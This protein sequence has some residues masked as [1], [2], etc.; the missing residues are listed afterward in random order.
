METD[1]PLGEPL[2]WSG[3]PA[4]EPVPLSGAYVELWPLDPARDIGPLY[5]A[6]HLRDGDPGV[7]HYLYEGPFDS[8]ADYKELLESED[9]D[10][11]ALPFT[12]V[13][14]S[15]GVPEGKAS[16]LRIDPPNGS[17]EV[18]NIWLGPG[19]KRTTAATEAIFLL[20]RHAF[21]DLGYRRFEW[22][23]NALNA[24]S[25][26]AAARFGFTYEGTFR[27]NVV[28]KG[29]NRDT[30]WFSIIDSEWP[31]IRAAFEAWLAPSN[32][33]ADGRQKEPLRA[34]RSGASE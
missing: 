9:A 21:D 25:R 19:L 31:E 22:K 26:A 23:C 6:S 11:G 24:P 2:D 13:P 5:A 1:R 8:E 14:T 4:P 34:A 29:R 7:W 15:T 28:V 16:Y 32:F 27:Q 12:I 10:P 17:I 20:I 30:A 3:A 18:G 33:D